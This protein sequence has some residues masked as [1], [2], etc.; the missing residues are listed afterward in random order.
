MNSPSRQW[1]LGEFPPK[2]A[3]GVTTLAV[4]SPRLTCRFGR[5]A[6][7][8]HWRSLTPLPCSYQV[9][10]DSPRH[11]RGK[12][13]LYIS[14]QRGSWRSPF[15]SP[16][17]SPVHK[18]KFRRAQPRGIF[19]SLRVI[20]APARLTRPRTAWEFAKL[21]FRSRETAVLAAYSHPSLKIPE[22]PLRRNFPVLPGH[23]PRNG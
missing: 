2:A 7:E 23:G 3:E 11:G 22:R 1:R 8:R 10:G 6:A 4:P 9:K 13:L 16:T 12:I 15:V 19:P 18:L 5:F 21:P 20:L 17:G 14:F